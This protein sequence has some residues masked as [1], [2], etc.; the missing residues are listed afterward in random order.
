MKQPKIDI[1]IPYEPNGQL[2]KDYNRIMS[3]SEQEWVLLLDHDVIVSLHPHWYYVC[4]QVIEKYPNSGLFTCYVSEIGCALQKHP[5]SP[6]NTEPVH[7]H[8]K[9]AKELWQQYKYEC[10]LIPPSNALLSGFF[11]L[12]KKS[13]WSEVGGF[14]GQG[15]YRE[16][17]Y[18]HKTL[19]E[20]NVPV[21]L[22][23]GLYC[24]HYRDRSKDV[25]IE[26]QDIN[27]KFINRDKREIKLK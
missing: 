1:R 16:D 17:N 8:K 22:I 24:Y 21:Y 15:M 23:Q 4:Q 13:V 20:H 25:W 27:T 2:G 9:F 10:K 19:N 7:I 5:N 26:N 12:I 14:L 11:F 3:E 18:Y 6:S